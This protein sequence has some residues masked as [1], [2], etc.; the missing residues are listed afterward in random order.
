M[1]II[2]FGSSKYSTIVA[3]ALFEK[4]GLSL[5][6][7]IPDKPVGRKQIIT[8]SP[9]KKIATE[10]G[11]PVLTFEKLNEKA[12]E[13]IK[14]YN[15]DFLVVADYGL[16]LPKELIELPKLAPLNV[17]HSLLPKYRGPSPAITAILN[18]DR[19]SGV[20]VIKMS[21]KM[22]T[23]DIFAQKEYE[24]KK[25]ETTYS[26]LKKLNELG[27]E[28]VI[29][30]INNFK[31]ITPVAQDESKA[32]YTQ[33]MKK[34]DGYFDINN[35]LPVE[36]IDRM[37]RAFYPWPNVWTRLRL[38]FGGQGKIVKFLPNQQIQVEGKKPMSIKDFV[39]GYPEM[40]DKIL[41]LF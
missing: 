2:S 3:R 30:V 24:L 17:H 21:E 37:T 13:E 27:A 12:I 18:G 38:S 32:T 16:L 26:L 5:V 14:K 33:K 39:N 36:T 25:E 8:P 31:Q 6:I 7:T 41:K 11:V 35:P 23:G 4:F 19:V 10:N 9:V 40:K 28:L 20:T 34:D 1:N 15:P 22:D 29:E